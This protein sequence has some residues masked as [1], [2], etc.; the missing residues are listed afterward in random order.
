[1][2]IKEKARKNVT[3]VFIIIK[4]KSQNSQKCNTL[5]TTTTNI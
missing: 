5:L 1:M 2:D 3:S 4:Q